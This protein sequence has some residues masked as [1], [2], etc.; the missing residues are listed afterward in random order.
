MTDSVERANRYRDSIRKALEWLSEH[1]GADG[2][3]GI[4]YEDGVNLIFTMAIAYLW[5]GMPWRCSGVVKRIRSF[6]KE[7]GSLYRPAS[8]SRITD[9]TQYPYAVGWVAR[10]GAACGAPDLARRCIGPILPLQHRESG[11]FF[12]SP[13][14][15]EKGEGII[16]MASTGMSGL[17]LLSACFV[18]RAREAGDYIVSWLARQSDLKDRLLPQWHTQKGLLDEESGKD[19][20]ANI[21]APLV[22]G[23]AAPHTGYWLN[24]ILVAFLAELYQVTAHEPFLTAASE[25]FDFA[26]R[27]PELDRTCFSHKFAWAA[28]T[29]HSVTGED[30]HL[31]TACR[32]AERLIRAQRPEGFFVYEDLFPEGETPPYP[33]TVSTTSQFTAWLSAVAMQLPSG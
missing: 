5:G 12:G 33:A 22:I 8:G 32:V 13:A 28:A 3:F 2:S 1:Q 25:L 14:E 24:G 17:A 9:Q 11:G 4:P 10:T 19:L 15:A 29:L 20:S 7:D 31:E 26:A 18:D 21:N 27:S 23:H 6:V 16:D 30:R